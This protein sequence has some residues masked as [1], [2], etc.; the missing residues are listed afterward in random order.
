MQDPSH[1]IHRDLQAHVHLL[2]TYRFPQLLSL[3]PDKAAEW[4]LNAPKIARDQAP[5]YWTYLDRPIDGTILLVWQSLSLGAEFP[6]DGYIWTPQEQVFSLEVNG[7]YTLEIYQ[8][9][10]G[11]SPPEPM[12]THSRRRYRLLPPKFSKPGVPN[13]DPS[14]WIV[15]YGQ[16]DP[17]DRLPSSVIP[18]DMRIQNIMSARAYLHAQGQIVQKEFMLHDRTN[19]PQIAFP[20]NPPRG[21]P[22]YGTNA[23][24][25][26]VPQTM[27]Y[28]PQHAVAGP[29]AKRVR[30]QA[31]VSQAAA[32]SAVASLDVDDEEDTSRGDLFDH[33]TPRE[34]SMSRYKQN[35]E[36]MEEILSSPYAIN[37]IIPADLGLGVRGELASLT[38]GIFDAPF[39]PD[40]DVVNNSYVGRLDAGKADQFRKRAHERVG[41]ISKEMEKMKA[42]H[43]KRLAKFQ[44]GSLI[45]AAEKQLRTAV[46][47]PSDTGPEY[48]RLEGKIDMED[49][50]DTKP[51]APTPS[52]VSDILAQ[53]E[54]SLS[55]H[56]A[57]MQEMVRIQDGGYE[58]QTSAPS[59]QVPTVP[60]PRASPPRSRNGSQHSGVLVGDADMDMGGSVAGLLD[61]FHT[62]IS[63]NATPGSNFPTPQPHLQGH[64]S[65]GTPTN[66]ATASPQP[67]AQISAEQPIQSDVNMSDNGT[68]NQQPAADTGEWVVVPPGG[69]SPTNNS[70]QAPPSTTS[71]PPEITAPT[72]HTVSTPSAPLTTNPSPLP[73]ASS[74]QTPLPDFHTSPNDFADLADLDTAGDALASYGEGLGGGDGGLGDLSMDMD[75]AMDDSAF[76]DAFHGV[77]ERTEGDGQGDGLP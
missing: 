25:A 32:S 63:S 9:K 61:Q 11:Y 58:E 69:V 28:P 36:W 49:D 73:T 14:L 18:V 54:A 52:K 65:V 48:W 41:Q 51:A 13:P 77:D 22:M 24:P 66:L 1:G 68:S 33:T 16:A 74:N 44:S 4:L 43:D 42:K 8:Q 3:H 72:A 38:E 76:G 55:R 56:V 75:G 31:N 15:H 46:H 62:G 37:Q 71:Q 70:A 67:S 2:S 10:T 64:S 59:P 27:A 12:A 17:Q 7:G 23:P 34:I 29:P 47:D 50:E 45:S 5:F 6:S 53:V 20:R 35:H 39:N 19:W 21:A 57:T 60:S 30:T 40:K 26:R